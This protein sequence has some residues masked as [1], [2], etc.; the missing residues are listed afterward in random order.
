[1]YPIDFT[2]FLWVSD[3]EFLRDQYVNKGKSIRQIALEQGC[4]H[5]TV[6][7]YLYEFELSLRQEEPPHQ[8]RGQVP[9]GSRM[10]K[11]R[12]VEHKGEQ[13]IIAKLALMRSQGRSFGD[14]VAW[15][16]INQIKTKSKTANWDRPTVYQILKRAQLST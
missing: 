6:S 10:V 5:S 12:L 4:S 8:R 15:L 13:A 11:G 16:D 3:K 1:L 7:Q 9:F 2:S 14:L